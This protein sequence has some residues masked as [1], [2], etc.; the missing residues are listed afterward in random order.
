MPTALIAVSLGLGVMAIVRSWFGEG[1]VHAGLWGVNVCNGSGCRG[2]RWDDVANA[3]FDLILAGY[4]G[5]AAAIVTAVLGVL[6][7]VARLNG[8]RGPI[9]PALTASTI[10]IA[11]IA[12]FVIRMVIDNAP[13]DWGSGVGVGCAIATA[14]LLRR[15]A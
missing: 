13:L 9:K 6:T 12:Y 10:A 4:A 14:V 15:R 1:G 11:A 8:Q 5:A 3:D 2:V 7:G